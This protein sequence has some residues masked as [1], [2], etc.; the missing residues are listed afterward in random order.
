MIL[1]CTDNQS[2][3]RRFGL[4]LCEGLTE[5]EALQKIGQV[6]EAVYNVEQLCRLAK[7]Y[8]VELPISEQVF[9]I[10]KLGVSP[11]QAVAALFARSLK[12]EL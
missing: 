3:N 7:E 6:V 11:R 4:A 5:S 10:V 1:T 9:Q 2:R 12:N 8:N